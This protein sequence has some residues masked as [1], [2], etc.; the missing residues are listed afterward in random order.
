MKKVGDRIKELRIQKGMSQEELA[1]AV[2]FSS[3]T[4]INKIE[5]N[6][7]GVR[8]D[9]LVSIATVLGTTPTYLLTGYKDEQLKREPAV[10]IRVVGDV[11]AGVP[12]DAID[13]GDWEDPDNWE[14]ISQS[15]ARQGEFFGLR[16]KGDSMSPRM[17][18]GDVVIVKKQTFADNG[19]I[20]VACVNGESAT[21]KKI[22][23]TDEGITLIGL[24]P[25][26]TPL[27]FSWREV[28]EMPLSIIG[29]V[30]ELR[31]KF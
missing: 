30:V 23:K 15:M 26:F 7:R 5:S 10:R 19:D 12:I 17:N 1:K 11:A 9:Y 18:E 24:N 22:K 8:A 4:S 31:A 21:C 27:F 16:L 20:V 14:E 2:G 6:E 28:A 13:D 29:K 3:K 25:A